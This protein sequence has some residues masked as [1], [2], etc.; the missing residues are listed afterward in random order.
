MQTL[1]EVMDGGYQPDYKAI[2]EKM[3]VLS[4][5]EIKPGM[6]VVLPSWYR[7]RQRQRYV[8]IVLQVC[9]GGGREYVYMAAMLRNRLPSQDR[10]T[11]VY[12]PLSRISSLRRH[13]K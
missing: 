7:L 9:D 3:R 4:L 1:G 10:R 13:G 6:A 5:G 2:E 12:W 11:F 8:N